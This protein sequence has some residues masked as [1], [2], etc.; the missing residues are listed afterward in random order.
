MITPEQFS[1][2][3]KQNYNRIPIIKEIPVNANTPMGVYKRLRLADQP[4]S[5]IFESMYGDENWGRYSI[6]G[7]AC[8]RTLSVAGSQLTIKHNSMIIRQETVTDPLQAIETYWRQFRTPQIGAISRFSGGLVG[9]FG[10]DCVNYIEPSCIS[11]NKDDILQCPDILLMVSERLLVFD[12]LNDKLAI[13]IH[14]D[15]QEENAYEKALQQIDMLIEQLNS[16]KQDRP[17]TKT[18]Q[19]GEKIFTSTFSEQQFEQNVARIKNYIISGDVMQ[20]VLSQRL[21]TKFN[22]QPAD[23]YCALRQLNPSPY[24]FHLNLKDF[25]I[26]GSSPEILVRLEG[27]QITV[28]PIAGT[29]SRGHNPEK[30]QALAQELLSDPKELSEH[31]MLIDLGRNDIGRV[32]ET[33]SVKLTDKMIIERYSHVM[34]IVSNV[35]GTIRQGQTAINLLKATFPAG[36]VSGAPKIR[37]MQ[38]IDELEPTKRGIYAGAIGY[39]AWNGNMD[40]AIAIRTAIIKDQ[41][42]HIQAGA[43]IVTDSIASNEWQETLNKGRAILNA[44]DMV[45]NTT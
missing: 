18:R 39:L 21:T 28:R 41:Q 17:I 1:R 26:V 14:V 20:V 13:I 16:D 22:R 2:L 43:G 6:I 7:L 44:V 27:R 10:Y 45:V 42:L 40:T 23:L 37:A 36:T 34:H 32:A 12:N 15:P 11:I 9:Y 19:A 29:R 25:H 38:I 31:L 3:A 4:Y 8:Q 5:Y 30:D 24:M 35:I 33:G